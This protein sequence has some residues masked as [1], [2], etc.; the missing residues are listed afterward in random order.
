[1]LVREKTIFKDLLNFLL[2]DSL[3]DPPHGGSTP[4]VEIWISYLQFSARFYSISNDIWLS[5]NLIEIWLSKKFFCCVWLEDIQSEKII[6]E[7]NLNVIILCVTWSIFQKC[8]TYLFICQFLT[9]LH[10]IKCS[11]RANPLA[12]SQGQVKLN[13][14]KWKLWKNLFE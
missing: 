7:S 12:R 8:G 6:W 3:L 11:L 5:W 13:S 14:D 9:L 10:W 1:L 4:S 2:S